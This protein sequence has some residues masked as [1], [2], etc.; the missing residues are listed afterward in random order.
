M[1]TGGREES[2]THGLTDGMLDV[3][4]GTVRRKVEQ[5]GNKEHY[6]KMEFVSCG[7]HSGNEKAD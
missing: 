6:L 7:N 4:Q 2:H 1:K 3:P 5:N